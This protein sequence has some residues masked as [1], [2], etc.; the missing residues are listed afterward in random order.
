MSRG[1][2]GGESKRAR[3]QARAPAVQ[4]KGTPG[5][6]LKFR[7]RV[8]PVL[9]KYSEKG[10]SIRQEARELRLELWSKVRDDRATRR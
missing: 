1:E 8:A 6:G 5:K 10:E 2:G 7:P 4:V 9:P 3:V